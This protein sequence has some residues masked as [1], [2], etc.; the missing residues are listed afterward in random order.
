MKRLVIAV[1]VILAAGFVF[2]IA[3]AADLPWTWT[4]PT[5]YTDGTTM[6][7]S[8]IVS[9]DVMYG[10]CSADK[11]TIVGTPVVVNVLAPATSKTITGVGSGIW[12]GSVR[13]NT[14]DSQSAFPVDA[15]TGQLA[16]KQIVLTPKP[17][18]NM[19]VRQADKYVMLPVGTVPANTVCDPD[20]GVLSNGKAYYAVPGSAITWYGATQ[21]TVALT[22]CS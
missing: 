18:G 15:T 13:T 8:A 5:Q 9:Y 12:C 21:P 4:V 14:A 7:S 3:K 11:K 2:E 20:N 6:P 17:P 10:T 22:T 1:L 19:A 16:W